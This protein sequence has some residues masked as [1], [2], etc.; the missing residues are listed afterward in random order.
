VRDAEHHDR[1]GDNE[2][3]QQQERDIRLKHQREL[4]ILVKFFTYCLEINPIPILI[5]PGGD[6]PGS[7]ARR[8][9][10]VGKR[11]ADSTSL[12]AIFRPCLDSGHTS[13][14][15]GVPVF[16]LRTCP[17]SPIAGSAAWLA[18]TR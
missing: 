9:V 11:P 6:G 13:P 2:H 10:A 15:L 1:V 7:A 3:D 5:Q 12:H 17:S 8:A 4:F 18:S 14:L 16:S